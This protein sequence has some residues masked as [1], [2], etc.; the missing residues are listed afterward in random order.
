MFF[1]LYVRDS[2]LYT[3][4]VRIR[5]WIE[6]SFISLV[7]LR[8]IGLTKYFLYK[9]KGTNLTFFPLFLLCAQFKGENPD[10][11]GHCGYE[12]IVG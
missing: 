1:I 4:L 6:T 8:S 11:L 9:A 2:L 5:T 7:I 10:Q 12:Y 3:T